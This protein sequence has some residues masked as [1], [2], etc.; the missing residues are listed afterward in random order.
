MPVFVA[1]KSIFA[2]TARD[3]SPKIIIQAGAVA[4]RYQKTAGAQAG[5]NRQF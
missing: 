5:A 2:L 1:A 4:Q 3:T